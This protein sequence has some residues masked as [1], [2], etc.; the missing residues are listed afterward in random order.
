MEKG[1]VEEMELYRRDI[2]YGL[3]PENRAKSIKENM[4]M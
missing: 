2:Y 4:M 1:V 3:R